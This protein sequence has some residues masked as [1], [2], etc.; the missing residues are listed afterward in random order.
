MIKPDPS[1]EPGA[2]FV[3]GTVNFDGATIGL[4]RQY[5]GQVA[6]G[7]PGA[8]FEEVKIQLPVRANP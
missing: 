3:A 1:S 8:F 7:C 6:V 5:I 4:V 2:Q